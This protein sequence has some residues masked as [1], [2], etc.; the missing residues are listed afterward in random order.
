LVIGLGVLNRR[1][2]RA[3]SYLGLLLALAISV[4]GQDLGE[5]YTGEAT[6]PN[7]GPLIALIALAILARTRGTGGV[8]GSGAP[9]TAWSRKRGSGLTAAAA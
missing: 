3:A 5:L 7:T 6:D 8:V 2:R 4:I 1:T 9:R